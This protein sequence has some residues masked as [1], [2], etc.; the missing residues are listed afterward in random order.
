MI[1]Y[2]VY[3]TYSITIPQSYDMEGILLDRWRLSQYIWYG[4][5]VLRGEAN[6]GLCLHHQRRQD[7]DHWCLFGSMVMSLS[8]L[9]RSLDVQY[10][11]SRVAIIYIY[12]S[13][14]SCH[15]QNNRLYTMITTTTTTVVVV[16][17]DGNNTIILDT[18]TLP[19]SNPNQT[20]PWGVRKRQ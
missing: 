19:H 1:W 12:T 8:W 9:L 18:T 10:D 20:L 16:V 4:C 17:W 14:G 11:T 3:R 2:I 13:R 5:C 6:S 15:A 7:L